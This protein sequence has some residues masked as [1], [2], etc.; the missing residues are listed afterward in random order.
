M[1][2]GQNQVKKDWDSFTHLTDIYS[3][4]IVQYANFWDCKDE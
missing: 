1:N 4:P 2:P 3:A